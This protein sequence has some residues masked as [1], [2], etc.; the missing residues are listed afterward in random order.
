MT[1]ATVPQLVLGTEMYEPSRIMKSI[2]Y[3]FD[4]NIIR[5]WK[6][7]ILDAYFDNDFSVLPIEDKQKNQ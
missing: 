6:D 4:D 7:E 5:I 1:L 3:I 2:Q